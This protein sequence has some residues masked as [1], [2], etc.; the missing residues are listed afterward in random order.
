MRAVYIASYGETGSH[1]L[2]AASISMPIHERKRIQSNMRQEIGRELYFKDI[3]YENVKQPYNA[4]KLFQKEPEMSV[5]VIHVFRFY[6]AHYC[7]VVFMLALSEYEKGHEERLRVYIPFDSNK[8]YLRSL[9]K[10]AERKK[11]DISFEEIRYEESCFQRLA[12]IIAGCVFYH[13]RDDYFN[14]IGKTGKAQLTSYIYASKKDANKF[15]FLQ[16]KKFNNKKRKHLV[17]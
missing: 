11:V 16:P 10:M 7:K 12:S 1:D 4:Y 9:N 3:S 5:S 6:R 8:G 17:K 14:N 15:I 2:T 13:D